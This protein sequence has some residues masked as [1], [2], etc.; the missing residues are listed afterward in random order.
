MSDPPDTVGSG[1]SIQT[2]PG[3]VSQD[4]CTTTVP[5][6]AAEALAM[7]ES[8]LGMQECALRFLAAEDAAGLPAPGGRGPAAGPGTHRRGRGRRPRPA[9]G[10]LRR[11]GR[12]PGRRA[13]QHPDLAGPL[14]PGHQGPG[15]RVPGGPGAGPRPPG[16]A[17]GAGRGLGC[18]PSPSPCSWPGGPRPSRRSTGARP[19]KSWSPP[20]GPART[21]GRWRRSAR[22]SAPAP[23]SPTPTTRMTRGWTAACPWRPRSTVPGS[24]TVT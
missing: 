22:R 16:A 18:S 10:G 24:S 15:R 23:P 20:P 12:A 2:R 19:R 6:T 7:L 3:E 11:P 17:R 5:A 4:M 9:A 14:D 21:C 8:A 13:A 1:N